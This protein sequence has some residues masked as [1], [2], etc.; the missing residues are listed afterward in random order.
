M[1]EVHTYKRLTHS[2]RDGWSYMDNDE[3]L[4]T[5]KLTPRKMVEEGAGY[6][7]GDTYLQYVRVPRN[8]KAAELAQALRDTMGGSNCRHEYDCCGCA[9]RYVSTKLVAPRKLQVR[10]S[11]TYNY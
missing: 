5:V 8:V 4:A 3:F 2:Y 7:E 10:T 9:T 6:D 1:Q 11:V